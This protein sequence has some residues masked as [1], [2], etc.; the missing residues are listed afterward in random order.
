MGSRTRPPNAREEHNKAVRHFK[1]FSAETLQC[2]EYS[3]RCNWKRAYE[4]TRQTCSVILKAS[5][6]RSATMPAV[7]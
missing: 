5:E 1:A 3:L 7:G 6:L 2:N 4:Q